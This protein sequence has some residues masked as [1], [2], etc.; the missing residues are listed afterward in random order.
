[1]A[2]ATKPSGPLD[3]LKSEAGGLAE[4]FAERAVSAARDK[5]EDATGR[6]TD[7]VESGA[8]PG[9]TA[10]LTGAKGLAEGKSPLR[11]LLGAGTSGLKEKASG[12][13]GGGKGKG[14]GGTK[15]LKIT[16]I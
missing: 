14:K 1:M 5:V 12:L 13:F 16:N 6:L 4:A 11:A 9:L 15:K 10:A 7:Y 3:R 2:R 8:G